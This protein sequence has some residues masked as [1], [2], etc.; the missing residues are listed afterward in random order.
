MSSTH[1][2]SHNRPSNMRSC[3]EGP[4][5]P[6]PGVVLGGSDKPL[7]FWKTPTPGPRS[8]IAPGIA[9]CCV[10][11]LICGLISF[12]M[13]VKRHCEVTIAS[14]SSVTARR[15]CMLLPAIGLENNKVKAPPHLMSLHTK[16]PHVNSGV[17][18]WFPGSAQTI[19]V[20]RLLGDPHGGPPSS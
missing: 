16:N 12:S 20:P 4:G 11:L 3:P 15:G 9:V 14:R 6:S 13:A 18:C 2:G 1:T 17:H 19:V 7:S 5:F 10:E 8:K